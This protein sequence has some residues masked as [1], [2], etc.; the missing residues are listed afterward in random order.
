MES[1]IGKYFAAMAIVAIAIAGVV[2][3]RLSI[4]P[5]E[6]LL[7]THSENDV[8]SYPHFYSSNVTIEPRKDKD[9]Y[10]RVDVEYSGIPDDVD[11]SLTYEFW[12]VSMKDFERYY[13]PGN[14][15]AMGIFTI[16]KEGGSFTFTTNMGNSYDKTFDDHAV[17]PGDY[18]FVH[19]FQLPRGIEGISADSMTLSIFV[20]YK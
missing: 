9:A 20:V 8:L 2:G 18:V 1:R 15:T 12:N 4:Q 3:I 10:L 6:K 17:K 19:Y 7:L 5:E 14:E 13:K 11:L 16:R